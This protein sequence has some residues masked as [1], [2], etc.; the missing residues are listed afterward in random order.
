M[1]LLLTKWKPGDKARVSW[2]DMRPEVVTVVSQCAMVCPVDELPRYRC[3][4]HAG[5]QI[6]FCSSVMFDML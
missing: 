3:Q 2:Q 1:A 6:D 4:T 5:Q